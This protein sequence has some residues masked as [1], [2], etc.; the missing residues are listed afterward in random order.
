MRNILA[1][2]AVCIAAANCGSAP[3]DHGP[4]ADLIVLAERR[5][6]LDD[7][8]RFELAAV[9]DDRS[10]FDDAIRTDDDVLSELGLRIDDGGRVDLGHGSP[11][12]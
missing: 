1:W 11:F 3:A 10:R 6:A 4:F 7:R 9:A 8:P 12:S 2:S 5:A